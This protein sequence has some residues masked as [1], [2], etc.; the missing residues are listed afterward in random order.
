[1]VLTMF[2]QM[3]R[4]MPLGQNM[5][6]ETLGSYSYNALEEFDSPEMGEVRRILAPYRE[7]A[8]GFD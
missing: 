2:A 8:F 7:V 6:S 3:C 4:I 5:Q 1:M